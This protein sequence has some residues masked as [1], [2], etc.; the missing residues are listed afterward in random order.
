MKTINVDTATNQQLDWLVAKCEKVD[1]EWLIEDNFIHARTYGEFCYST[2]WSQGGPIIE[3]ED[4]TTT[5]FLDSYILPDEVQTAPG[6]TL[7]GM[8]RGSVWTAYCGNV[9]M[10]QGDVISKQEATGPTPLIAA[11][12]CFVKSKLGNTVEVPEELV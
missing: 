12:R 4:I 3:R 10:Y 6:K 8:R 11:M 2:D 5:R 7:W 1:A 9:K